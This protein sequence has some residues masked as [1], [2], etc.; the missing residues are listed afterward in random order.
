[1]K[2]V[3][4]YVIFVWILRDSEE[5]DFEIKVRTLNLRTE[6]KSELK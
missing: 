3:L 2:A 4:D 6:K 1:M 5:K